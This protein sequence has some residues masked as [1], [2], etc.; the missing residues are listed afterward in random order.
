MFGQGPNTNPYPT[1]GFLGLGSANL[2]PAKLLHLHGAPGLMS[3]Q[4]ADPCIRL[5]A[6]ITQDLTSVI[7]WGHIAILTDDNSASYLRS[8]Q[9]DGIGAISMA[10]AGDMIVESSEHGGDLLLGTRNLNSNIVFS[11]YDNTQY[12]IASD[13]SRMIITNEGKVG[14]GLSVPYGIFDVMLSKNNT[15]AIK[16][17]SRIMFLQEDADPEIFLFRPDGEFVNPPFTKAGSWRIKGELT[18]F[19]IASSVDISGTPKAYQGPIAPYYKNLTTLT[20]DGNFGV[21]QENP[22]AKLQVT[23]GSVLFNGITGSTP[24]SGAGTRFMW[25]PEKAALRAGK[26]IYETANNDGT[27]YWNADNIG[28]YSIASG[29]NNLAQSYGSVALGLHCRVFGEKNYV[30]QQGTDYGDGHA[31]V[32][33]GHDCEVWGYHS[34]ALGYSNVG[35]T[36][37][38]SQNPDVYH[39]YKPWDAVAIG[40]ASAWSSESFAFGYSAE[41]FS[42]GSFAIGTNAQAGDKNN[43]NDVTRINSFAIG[44][45][46]V[47]KGLGSFVIGSGD[48]GNELVNSNA[49]CLMIGINSSVS[50]L[51]VGGGDGTS[52]DW[53]GVGVA[54]TSVNQARLRVNTTPVQ[55]SGSNPAVY[56]TGVVIGRSDWQTGGNPTVPEQNCDLA[57]Q[58][59][60]GIGTASPHSNLSIV[61]TDDNNQVVI[62]STDQAAP[63]AKDVDL[64]VE[65]RVLIGTNSVLTDANIPPTFNYLLHVNGGVIKPGGGVWTATSD[66]RYKKDVQPFADGL[67]KLRKVN[68]V[69]YSYNGRMGLPTTEKYIGVIAQDIQ[70]VLPYTVN[71]ATISQ[72]VVSKPEKRY[73][74]D[75][76]DTTIIRV[77][78]YS[79]QRDDHGHYKYKDSIITQTSKRWVIEPAESTTE[80]APILTYD[81]SALTYLLV[82]SLKEVDSTLNS[83]ALQTDGQIEQLSSTIDSL[84]LIISNQE[85][86]IIRLE[87]QNSIN[88]DEVSD[89]ILEQNNPNPYSTTTTIT[90]YIPSAVQGNPQLVV[91]RSS[92]SQVLL[93]FDV[94]K[95]IPTQQIIDATTLDTGV[96]AYTLIVQGKVLAS[97][98]MIVIK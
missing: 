80:T 61:G 24:T 78:D 54:T 31:G 93:S 12:G 75:A 34:I 84:K 35:G 91:T 89:V 90:Y 27:D 33:I 98:K 46:V 44:N 59:R 94:V 53:G 43:I 62:W 72:T 56:E 41:T 32:A 55:I 58:R 95:G 48:G 1:T 14:I 60:V 25:V 11:T 28:E 16:A 79:A 8:Y 66:I 42:T 39:T 22:T 40:N 50:T 4:I 88:R 7:K 68:P 71:E 52:G 82:N 51:Y 67:E 23:D 37:L 20:N 21:N 10:N 57:V 15:E 64:M 97:K 70:Q 77:A 76:T 13:L 18:K 17:G 49:N 30:N 96:Y 19:H 26:L 36:K 5:S 92:G 45:G 69:W 38:I 65:K 47:A 73:E 3:G 2:P 81:G 83:K 63:S 85:S 74:V 86:R 87:A 29:Y 9:W 6:Y